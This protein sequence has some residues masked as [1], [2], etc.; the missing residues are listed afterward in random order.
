[1]AQQLPEGS[2]PSGI[3]SGQ[4]VFPAGY[5][6][7]AQ[8][9]FGCR[10]NTTFAVSALAHHPTRRTSHAARQG[11]DLLLAQGSLPAHSLGHQVARTVG[12]ERASGFF[13][14]FARPDAALLLDLCWRIGAS[15]EDTR[16]AELVDFVT[17]LQGPYGLWEYSAQPEAARWI[18]FDLLR[19]LARVAR[20]TDWL[21]TEPP[22]PFQPYP[23]RERR[24]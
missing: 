13:T 2:W 8:S 22:L 20:E 18:T 15:R 1:M 19:S 10:T 17:A 3:K 12:L 6:R 14:Y 4:T 7:L 11:L 9:R 24:Y 21:G 23:K 5:R 16:V